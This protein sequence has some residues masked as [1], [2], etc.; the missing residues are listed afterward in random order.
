MRK[1]GITF[2]IPFM[3]LNHLKADDAVNDFEKSSIQ[4]NQ[5]L[6]DLRKDL[7]TLYAD[8]LQLHQE[9]SGSDEYK[10][11]IAKIDAI[12]KQIAM[13]QKDWKTSYRK[14][15]QEDDEAYAFWD[16]GETT[17]SQLIMEYGST[18]YLY[19]IPYELSN[20]KVHTYSNIAI[21]Q[22]SW[23]E[24]L[25]AILS[26]Y[27]IGVKKLNPFLRQ[28]YILK[29][30][31][32]HVEGIAYS[33]EDLQTLEDHQIV[34]YIFSPPI[35]KVKTV[36]SFLDRFSDP[37]QSMIQ[38]IGS[39]IA[40]T[41]S[42]ENIV[43]LMRLYQAT[44]EN[45]SGKKVSLLTL[46]KFDVDEAEKILKNYFQQDVNK[47]RSTFFNQKGPEVIIQPLPSKAA[48]ALIGDEKLVE[49]AERVLED[50]EDQIEDPSE[51]TIFWYT[52]K[53]S[54]PEDL[55]QILDKVYSSLSFSS[56]GNQSVKES[57]NQ[58]KPDIVKNVCKEPEKTS[59]YCPSMPVTP[60]MVE[61]G[62]ID[63][64]AGNQSYGNFIVDS[65]TGSILMVVKKEVLGKIKT[66]LKRLDVP[67]KMAQID[68]LL[69]E[70]KIQDRKQTGIN[71]LKIGTASNERESAISFDTN[72][73]AKN[74]GLLDFI[75]SRPKGKLPAFD[76][77]LGFLMGKENVK[78]NA[79]PSVLAV[80]QTPAIIS[81]VEE[82]SI[83]NGAIQLDTVS[84]ITVEKSYTRAQ[85]G[86]TI[87]MTPTIHLPLDENEKGYVTLKTNVTFDTTQSSVDD[88]PPVTRRH[89]E[90]E[91]RIADGE[92]II[93]GGLRKN[94]QEDIRENIPFLGEIPG[95][96]KMF[97][98]TKLLD[99]STEMI[100]FITPKII[101]DPVHDLRVVKNQYMQRR[102]GDIPELKELLDRAKD[103][104]KKR[105]FSESLQLFF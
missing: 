91:V 51:M 85:F 10:T 5:S 4:M 30:D 77:A 17:L 50:M 76:L 75:I 54:D 86:I 7:Q 3:I 25:E 65:K 45:E 13:Q 1:I 68:V 58:Q 21:P 35:E 46:K 89:I 40:I 32:S 63:Q 69:V 48:I 14:Q 26:N 56:D 88:R 82:I 61:P 38:I 55:A 79:N 102:Q 94:S 84:G 34:F 29:H 24:M 20:M 22:E 80:N 6:I 37:K 87:T 53:H 11:L 101:Q 18:D 31:P 73:N 60:T 97:G 27:G 70:R 16:Q 64:K 62:L 2:L 98:T 71:L 100:F 43:K 33:L 95:I 23:T 57:I 41:A 99:N 103:E 12:K 44:L 92:T 93:L 36:Q 67:K 72:Q 81:I 52:C 83:N 28:L 9:N 74:K 47:T 15:E 96:G 90:N 8:A 78:I 66:L 39:K 105:I 42:K 59:A 49:K 19:V 104:E